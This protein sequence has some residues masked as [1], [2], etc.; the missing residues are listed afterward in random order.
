MSTRACSASTRTADTVRINIIRKPY[1][2]CV[3]SF[4]LGFCSSPTIV[5]T[6]KSMRYLLYAFSHSPLSFHVQHITFRV[7]VIGRK[8]DFIKMV[9]SFYSCKQNTC[10]WKIPNAFG[11]DEWDCRMMRRWSS[12]KRIKIRYHKQQQWARTGTLAMTTLL[13]ASHIICSISPFFF[14]LV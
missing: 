12:Q 7:V 5:R 3:F 14:S 8:C 6:L 4:E 10:T 2:A 1:I 11:H 13:T 9:C